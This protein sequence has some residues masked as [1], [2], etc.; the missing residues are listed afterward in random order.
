MV[1]L[2]AADAVIGCWNDKYYWNFWRPIDVIRQVA[3]DGNPS[4]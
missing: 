3:T 2:A 4:T 1:D